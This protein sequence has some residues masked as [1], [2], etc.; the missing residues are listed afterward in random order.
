MHLL[1][2]LLGTFLSCKAFEVAEHVRNTLQKK[3]RLPLACVFKSE[4]FRKL[5]QLWPPGR[6]VNVDAEPKQ[7]DFHSVSF[8][9]L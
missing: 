7:V 1:L 3:E 6:V 9:I 4:C 2:P 5:E 8:T